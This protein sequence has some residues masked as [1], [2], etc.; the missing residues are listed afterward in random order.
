MIPPSVFGISSPLPQLSPQ[1]FLSCLIP[2]LWRIRAERDLQEHKDFIATGGYKTAPTCLQNSPLATHVTM[3]L[4]FR[5]GQY[6]NVAWWSDSP[7]VVR[8]GI[9]RP[10]L[11]VPDASILTAILLVRLASD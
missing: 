2:F 8:P 3:Q 7:V 6:A 4:P 11:L 9:I 10:F 1:S 5:F